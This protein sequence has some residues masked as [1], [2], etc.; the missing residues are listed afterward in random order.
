GYWS[1]TQRERKDGKRHRQKEKKSGPAGRI[2]EERERRRE[3]ERKKERK[4][5]PAASDKNRHV[6]APQ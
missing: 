6:Q 4:R 1:R 5:K 3:K 2:G